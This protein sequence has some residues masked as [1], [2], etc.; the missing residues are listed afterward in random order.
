[1][2]IMLDPGSSRPHGAEPTLDRTTFYGHPKL[3]ASRCGHSI[4]PSASAH[5]PTCPA[6][7][8]SRQKTSMDT[9]LRSLTTEG[10][11]FPPDYMRDRRWQRAKLRYAIAKQQQTKARIK[12]QLRVERETAWEEAHQRAGPQPLQATTTPQDPADCPACAALE[13]CFPTKMSM[14]QIAKDV[15]WW[16]RPGGLACSHV[17]VRRTPPRPVK[18]PR[19]HSPNVKS[20]SQLRA[21]VYGFRRAMRASD[22]QRELG[23]TRRRTESAVRRKHG[24][25]DDILF[26][27]GFWDAPI[28]GPLSRQNYQQH[29]ENQ[30]RQARSARGN[31]N[32][33]KPP[34]SS[35]SYAK[36]IEEDT[37]DEE[38]LDAIRERE[39][40][41]ALAREASRVRVEVG[42]LYFV[43]GMNRVMEC[44]DDFMVSDRQLVYRKQVQAAQPEPEM[45]QSD[46]EDSE[47]SDSDD[48]DEDDD[49]DEMD[50][51]E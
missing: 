5:T 26:E 19:L 37:S 27:N 40:Q 6:C 21:L 2:P 9:A 14:Q 31:T 10:G 38:T 12:D 43:G 49:D 32:R 30:L 23:M 45:S 35:L 42:Y 3:F 36:H 8:T 51:D 34:R 7:I 25:G 16:E 39:R 18:R 47:K 13:A 50:I 46:T 28:S 44:K 48:S 41:E 15:A 1:M 24:L 22:A 17:L 20:S 29:Y 11:L 33:P 4:H